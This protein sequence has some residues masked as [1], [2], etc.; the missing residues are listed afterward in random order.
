MAHFYLVSGIYFTGSGEDFVSRMAKSV[1]PACQQF[2]VSAKRQDE[3]G[4][5]RGKAGRL[6]SHV[7]S[8]RILILV[9]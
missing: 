5:L 8:C 7:A 4:G 1:P 9:D 6:F 2:L 3:L